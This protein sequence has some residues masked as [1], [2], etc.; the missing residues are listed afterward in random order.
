MAM[1]AS[2]NGPA[3]SRGSFADIH[4]GFGRLIEHAS[5]RIRLLTGDIIGSGTVGT[6][7]ILKVQ[8]SQ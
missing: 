6:V 5:R 8:V 4:W 7:C 3:Y 2:V 1:T